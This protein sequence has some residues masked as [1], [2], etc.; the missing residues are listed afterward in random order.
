MS[1]VF[2]VD[3]RPLTKGFSDLKRKQLPYATALA[4]TATAGHI[5]V[6]WQDEMLDVLDR[7]TPF[8]LKSVGVRG[9]RKTRLIASVFVKDIAS[10]YLA[11]YVFGG[12]HS[13]GKKK[14]LLTPI[15]VPVN[16]YGNLPRNKLAQLKNRSGVHVGAVKLRSG[17]VVNGVWKRPTNAA[18]RRA[19]RQGGS[20][21]L[22]LLIR[23]D[24][25]QPV[26][27]H[28]DFRGRAEAAIRAHFVPEFSRALA[29][30][31]ATAK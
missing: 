6:A 12:L 8:T 26:T 27:Q 2:S 16:A 5:G 22:K 21:A 1:T 24:D 30:A 19:G 20:A 4:L 25:P 15:G 9:A 14:G 3:V 31:L 10:E 17:Q 23:F 18:R 11:P 7:P 29:K 28:L 13:L